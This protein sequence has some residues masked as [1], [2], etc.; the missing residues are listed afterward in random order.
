MTLNEAFILAEDTIPAF[1]EY[2][3]R[4][5]KGNYTGDTKES[6]R[7]NYANKY[8]TTFSPKDKLLY[9]ASTNEMIGKETFRKRSILF[10]DINYKHNR[11]KF[12]E[13]LDK[14]LSGYSIGGGLL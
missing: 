1:C 7:L 3:N 4:A 6:T 13:L 2:A 8:G 11:E 10:W 5:L 12:I 9:G 14:Y